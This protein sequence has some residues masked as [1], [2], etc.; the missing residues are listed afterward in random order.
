VA[1]L[2]EVVAGGRE[3]QRVLGHLV[4]AVRDARQKAA[5]A[6]SNRSSQ[7]NL[8]CNTVN[9]KSESILHV[10]KLRQPRLIR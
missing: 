4:D 6:R 2:G 1:R 10:H 5:S 3:D 8:H 9:G 7:V